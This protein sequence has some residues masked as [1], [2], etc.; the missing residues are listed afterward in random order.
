MWVS[1]FCFFLSCPL[2]PPSLLLLILTPSPSI[3]KI[4]QLATRQITAPHYYNVHHSYESVVP[5]VE[6]FMFTL[7]RN[8]YRA[9]M[10]VNRDYLFWQSHPAL[11][12]PA[13]ECDC[14]VCIRLQTNQTLWGM[15]T[16]L[17]QLPQTSQVW[18]HPKLQIK[19]VIIFRVQA[20]R[21]N[22]L[23]L[24]LCLSSCRP[25]LLLQLC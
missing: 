3:A 11:F 6:V 10:E 20:Q 8:R 13:S 22:A 24:K 4:E 12:F 1:E 16:V 23:I 25:Y 19:H 2:D 18:V 5:D 21:P 7:Q 17:E 9:W 14:C 15:L